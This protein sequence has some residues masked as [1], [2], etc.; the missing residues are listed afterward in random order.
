GFHLWSES[1]DESVSDVFEIQNR[2]A[3]QIATALKVQLEAQAAASRP[4]NQAAFQALLEG[5]HLFAER[6]QGSNRYDGIAQFALATEL[7]PG[8]ADAWAYY[9]Y[10]LSISGPEEM[11]LSFEEMHRR[12]DAA[13]DRA[14]A[15]EPD[16]PLALAVQG[17]RRIEQ[18][19]FEDGLEILLGVTEKYPSMVEGQYALAGAWEVVGNYARSVQV[20]RRVL[21]LDPLNST[22]YRVYSQRLFLAGRVSEAMDNVAELLSLGTDFRP[23]AFMHWWLALIRRDADWRPVRDKLLER[24]AASNTPSDIAGDIEQVTEDLSALLSGRTGVLERLPMGEDR[25]VRPVALLYI[26]TLMAIREV[27][28]AADLVIQMID[29][30]SL[31]AA[32]VS[33]LFLSPVFQL[34]EAVLNHPAYLAMW[35]RPEMLKL[36]RAR[37]KYGTSHAIPPEIIVRVE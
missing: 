28:V 32:G 23:I 27:D 22:R 15:L 20:M 12:V 30:G 29:D 13:A 5:R 37:T 16:H 3:R 18:F 2:I 4:A 7:D 24:L 35:Q 1:Y 25:A 33:P 34:D 21:A 31:L 10:S 17:S 8:Y 11:G 14:L 36:A 6:H 9:A 26:N 19:S